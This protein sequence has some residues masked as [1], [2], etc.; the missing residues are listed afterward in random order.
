MVDQPV[1][2][3]SSVIVQLHFFDNGNLES[4]PLSDKIMNAP[5]N[6][7]FKNLEL[8]KYDNATGN[9]VEHLIEF[10]SKLILYDYN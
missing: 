2:R 3:K 4:F 1:Q 8:L 10:K 6:N 9:P 7:E 5:F